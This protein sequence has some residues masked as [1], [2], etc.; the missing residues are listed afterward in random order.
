MFKLRIAFTFLAV[1]SAAALAATLVSCNPAGEDGGS[2]GSGIVVKTDSPEVIAKFGAKSVMLSDL[3]SDRRFLMMVQDQLFTHMVYEKCASE[4]IEIT[5]ADVEEQ[6]NKLRK[7]FGNDDAELQNYLKAAGKTMESMRED[8]RKFV[9]ITK[10]LRKRIN[11]SDEDVRNFYDTQFRNIK[12]TV[13]AE[14]GLTEEETEA[15]TYEQVKDKADEM[16][17]MQRAN[18]EFQ[19][20]RADIIKEFIDKVQ[21]FGIPPMTL[22]DWGIEEP[23]E[24]P[25]ATEPPAPTPAPDATTP[26]NGGEQDSADSGSDAEAGGDAENGE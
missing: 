22:A 14:R 16:L 11:L 3:S 13:G 12:Q 4:R 10:L 2:P 5:E 18:E 21:Y 8:Q 26:Q 24:P 23:G 20:F 1:I 6:M 25:V 7:D 9:A 17:F 19:N 15:L